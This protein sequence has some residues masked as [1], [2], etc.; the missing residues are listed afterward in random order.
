MKSDTLDSPA[1]LIA[2]H[3][4]G[5]FKILQQGQT[6]TMKR[7]DEMLDS[8]NP[9]ADEFLKLMEGYW[10]C[11]EMFSELVKEIYDYESVEPT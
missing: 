1:Q 6:V 9:D 2:V 7:L 8:P 4:E 11:S 10:I 5:H 3:L